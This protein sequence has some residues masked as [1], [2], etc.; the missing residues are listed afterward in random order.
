MLLALELRDFVLVEDARIEFGPGLAAFTGETGTGK[1]LLVDALQLLAGARADASWVRH[2]AERALIQAEF[3]DAPSTVARSLGANGR[4]HARLDGERVTVGEV[5]EATRDRIAVFA[6]HAHHALLAPAAQRDA[7]DRLLPEEGA[8]ARDAYRA[9]YAAKRRDEDRLEELRAGARER[10]RR[11]DALQA[12]I[13]EIDAAELR[14]GEEEERTVEAERLRHADRIATGVAEALRALDEEPGALGPLAG[15]R[16]DLDGAARFDPHLAA[17]ARD[18]GE[19]AQGVQAVAD[20]LRTFLDAFDA[21]PARLDAVERRLTVLQRLFAKYGDGSADVLAFR[22]RSVRER[23]A[24]E[25]DDRSIRDL[26]AAAARHHAELLRHAAVLREGRE[27]AAE[28][29][30]GEIAPLLERLALPGARLGVRLDPVPPGPHGTERVAFELAANPGEPAAAIAQAASGGERSR[31]MLALWLVTG[32][33]RATLVFDEVDAGV[34]GAAAAAVGELLAELGRRHQ[35]LV[36]THLAQVAACADRQYRVA[37]RTA[38]RR[39]IGSVAQVDG[40]DRERELARMLAGHDGEPARR[41]ARDLLERA[42][43][44]VD[45][46]TS[47]DAA[48]G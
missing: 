43:R 37:K 23:D 5:Q 46:S 24:L 21:D 40:E 19:A 32:D 29:L 42:G 28:R 31:V 9:A 22:D 38:D 13:D 1:S 7:L 14:A 18:L 4:H 11:R 33:E 12:A 34:G 3:D 47:A 36:V 44:S 17:L 39:T 20:E 2:G 27:R 30:E 6:Q 15:A 48:L 45:E 25:E 16:R 8:R 41:A 10:L 26:E 35:V